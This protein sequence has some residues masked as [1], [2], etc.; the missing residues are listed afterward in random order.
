MATGHVSTQP[1]VDTLQH[2]LPDCSYRVTVTALLQGEA[3]AESPPC[4]FDTPEGEGNQSGQLEPC[5]V[6]LLTSYA[7]TT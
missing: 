6:M 1:G 2:L 7:S 3:V 4:G 5:D